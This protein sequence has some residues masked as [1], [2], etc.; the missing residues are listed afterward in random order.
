MNRVKQELNT[1]DETVSEKVKPS[2][3]KKQRR[4]E[5]IK[6]TDDSVSRKKVLWSEFISE[7]KGNFCNMLLNTKMLSQER[8]AFVKELWALSP[9]QFL[10]YID[11][12]IVPHANTIKKL[13]KESREAREYV[14][15][16][17]G[18]NIE[19][20]LYNKIV[21]YYECFQEVLEAHHT[22]K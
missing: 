21:R 9:E 6:A 5:P 18:V 19:D 16:M 12:Q 4:T 15:K 7:K 13:N 14:E 22:K 3:K 1:E 10:L 11:R 17:L 8:S 2:S 20:E